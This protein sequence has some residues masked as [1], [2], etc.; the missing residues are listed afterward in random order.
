MP[1]SG[2]I[3]MPNPGNA[4]M[5]LE[6]WDQMVKITGWLGGTRDALFLLEHHKEI[7]SLYE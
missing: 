2:N 4:E 3:E 1:K 6:V 5:R 7:I